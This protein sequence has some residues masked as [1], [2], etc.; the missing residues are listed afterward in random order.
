MT[1]TAAERGIA[2]VFDVIVTNFI[3]E[4]SWERVLQ[5]T[6][7]RPGGAIVDKLLDATD[8]VDSRALEPLLDRY[9]HS[10]I[11]Y[12]QRALDYAEGKV[13]TDAIRK[14]FP[15]YDESIHILDP[16]ASHDEYQTLVDDVVE[17]YC[18]VGEALEPLV[19][20]A[21]DDF[22]R[23]IQE[24]MNED[25]AVMVL[26]QSMSFSEILEAH[27]GILDMKLQLNPAHFLS[28]PGNALAPEASVEYTDEAIVALS[29]AERRGVRTLSSRVNSTSGK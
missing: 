16:D 17:Y 28:V 25:Q 26:D 9:R 14:E 21:S 13:S 11:E 1:R 6:S 3:D 5:K 10:A 12:F 29:R 27:R 20:H 4:F 24:S 15:A 2:E 7:L 19:S 23:V 22:W 18:E 8:V